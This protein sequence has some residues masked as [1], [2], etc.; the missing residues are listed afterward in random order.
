MGTHQVEAAELNREEGPD[1]V[2][3]ANGKRDPSWYNAAIK[4]PNLI[5]QVKRI[6]DLVSEC[7]NGYQ[8]DATFAKVIAAPTE[9]KHFSEQNGL[10]WTKN[11]AGQDVLCIPRH[12]VW[13]R[14]L[15]EIVINQAHIAIGHMGP[16]KTNE[17]VRRWYW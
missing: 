13:K 12:K 6:I 3:E 16:Q 17:Y 8:L 7:M 11:H 10:P 2:D 5:E 9:H 4:Q 14:Q 1:Q 15:T